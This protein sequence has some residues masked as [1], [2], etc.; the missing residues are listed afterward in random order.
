MLSF[1]A[2][3]K[4]PSPCLFS[5]ALQEQSAWPYRL[6]SGIFDLEPHVHKYLRPYAALRGLEA[7]SLILFAWQLSAQRRPMRLTS[8]RTLSSFLVV[9]MAFRCVVPKD[10]L[11][12]RISMPRCRINQDSAFGQP[13]TT[14]CS[15]L[16]CAKPACLLI[17]NTCQ[18]LARKSIACLTIHPPVLTSRIPAVGSANSKSQ[19][20]RFPHSKE[21]QRSD[22]GYHFSVS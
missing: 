18:E 12:I 1:S 15:F 16:A 22:L 6:S 3:C 14:T 4:S 13:C 7:T 19:N 8:D 9:T 17:P 10:M 2:D 5:D 21:N 20:C 11:S